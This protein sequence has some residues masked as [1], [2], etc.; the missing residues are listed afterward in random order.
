MQA[1]QHFMKLAVELSG[2]FTIYVPDRRGRGMS[3][4]FGDSYSVIKECEDVAALVEKTGAQNIFGLSSGATIA[5]RASLAIANLRKAALYEPALSV[6]GS[7]P[8]SWL[9][10]YERE[11]AQGKITQAL[12]TVFNG[13]PV[14]P[15]LFVRSPRFILAPA[16]ALATRFV[17]K[18]DGDDIPIKALVPTQHYDMMIVQETADRMEDYKSV[19]ADVLLLGGSKSPP[20]LK[21]SLDA[22][23]REL[24]SVRRKTLDGLDHLSA[25]NDGEPEI[26]AEELRRFFTYQ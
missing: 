25:A 21:T 19:G 3:G 4:P 17:D 23:E 9:P 5:L 8:M 11:I 16:L 7:I 10:R 1:S 2:Q 26:V 6:N 14:G 15:P 20:F 12:V 22:L 18:P 13:I 24:P